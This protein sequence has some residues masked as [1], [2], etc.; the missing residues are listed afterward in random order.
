M[1]KNFAGTG[2]KIRKPAPTCSIVIPSSWE[3]E[4]RGIEFHCQLEG[5][6]SDGFLLRSEFS[7][8]YIPLQHMLSGFYVTVCKQTYQFC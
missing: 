6:K 7:G 5:E 3:C 8:N 1:K 2:M 4:I